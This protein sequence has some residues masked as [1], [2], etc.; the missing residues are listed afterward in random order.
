M[1]HST[2]REIEAAVRSLLRRMGSQGD[3]EDGHNCPWALTSADW[4]LTSPNQHALKRTATEFA[5]MRALCNRSGE[6]CGR[7]YLIATL[8]RPRE[9]FDDRHLDAIVSRLR[10]KIKHH[11]NLRA[12]IEA[13]FGVGYTFTASVMIERRSERSRDR[14]RRGG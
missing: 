13:V 7:E 9:S 4:T 14:R 1:K 6:V 2:L 5:F 11:L 8:A 12:P 10:R 3:G